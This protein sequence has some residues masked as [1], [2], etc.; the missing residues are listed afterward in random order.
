MGGAQ[1]VEIVALHRSGE[2]FA[3]GH[4]GD[5]DLL[6]RHEMLDRQLGADIDEGVGIDAE[7]DQPALRLDAG[8]GEMTTHRLRHVLH[9]DRTDAELHAR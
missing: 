9:L 1:A 7:F 3:D 2:A 8:L 6:A 4:A 5:V